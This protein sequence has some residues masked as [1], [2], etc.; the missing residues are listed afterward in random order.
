MMR[1]FFY[2]QK[3]DRKVVL[4]L[5]AVIVIALGVIFLTGQ[6]NQQNVANSAPS[7]IILLRRM[8]W[9]HIQKRAIYTTISR[10]ST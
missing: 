6:S 7:D 1:E 3:S 4:A 9:N 5:L 10:F 2:L 8:P